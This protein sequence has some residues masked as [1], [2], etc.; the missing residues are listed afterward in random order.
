MDKAKGRHELKYRIGYGD[1]LALRARAQAL[2]EADAHAEGSSGY[3]VR[4]IYFDNY[5]DTALREKLDGLARREKFRLR[6][7][8]ADSAHMRLEKKAKQ[9]ALCF[10]EGL[11]LREAESRMLL[12][13]DTA[14]M[15]EHPAPLLRALYLKMQ[16]R[17]LRPRVLVSYFREAYVYGPGNVRLTFDSDIRTSLFTPDFLCGCVET[18]VGAAEGGA[19]IRLMELKY[20]DFLPEPVA[21]LVQG[22]PWRQ[23][24]FSKYGAA[25]RF[26]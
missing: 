13:L 8:G 22:A 2:L 1:Y 14:F 7:Y 18:A 21:A 12:S 26:G 20:D 24:A 3:R 16:T 6:F 15:R 5:A 25:R 23:G 11:R 17:L 4:S 9:G 19:D 10:K